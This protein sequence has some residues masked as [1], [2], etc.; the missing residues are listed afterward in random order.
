MDSVSDLADACVALAKIHPQAVARGIVLIGFSLGG[1][2]ALRLAASDYVPDS[3]RAVVSVS[4]PLDLEATSKRLSRY[5]N[6]PY[7]HWL[8]KR[9][10]KESE[11]IWQSK[12]PEIGTVLARVRSLRS[13]D[14]ILTA[15]EAGFRDVTDYYA[16][17]S[18]LRSL[19]DLRVPSLLLHADDDPWIPPPP[20]D[21]PQN[22]CGE[23]KITGYREEPGLG[24]KN[25][26][27]A[28]KNKDF[29]GV[30]HPSPDGKK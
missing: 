19:S 23:P 11:L 16:S 9:L 1:A 24:G 21:M 15:P 29:A 2:L 5:R 13:F 22:D 4:A 25:R 6:R 26:A 30:S 3:L 20:A 17:C 8:L 10:R 14:N 7:E 18:P 28:H 27:G 12:L